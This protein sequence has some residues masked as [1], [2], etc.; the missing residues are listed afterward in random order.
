MPLIPITK[1]PIG[2]LSDGFSFR[3]PVDFLFSSP[4]KLSTSGKRFLDEVAR[5][6]RLLPYDLQVQAGSRS[7][8][9][10]AARV[11]NYLF[12]TAG[13]HPGRLGVALAPAGERQPDDVLRIALIRNR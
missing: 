7:R 13:I 4:D 5:S 1:T 12:E 8:M 3:V 11:N 2:K 9:P 6:I 10:A